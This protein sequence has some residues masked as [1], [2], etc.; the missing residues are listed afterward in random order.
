M[1]YWLVVSVI[2]RRCRKRWASSVLMTWY[3]SIRYV[4]MTICLE[5]SGR[6]VRRSSLE[7]RLGSG[8]FLELC[9]VSPR[10]EFILGHSANTLISCRMV[11]VDHR[12]SF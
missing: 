3:R 9:N 6:A 11:R 2:G 4:V 12:C 1:S 7:L 8:R 10:L 5:V